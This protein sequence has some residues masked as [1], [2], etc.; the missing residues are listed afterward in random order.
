MRCY[1]IQICDESNPDHAWGPVITFPMTIDLVAKVMPAIEEIIGED[2][3]IR[4][5]DVES[6]L[7]M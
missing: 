3:S 6:N 7:M 5:V 1:Q 4:V 2:Y